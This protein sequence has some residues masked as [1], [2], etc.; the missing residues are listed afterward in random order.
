VIVLLFIVCFSSCLVSSFRRLGSAVIAMPTILLEALRLPVF[1]RFHVFGECSGFNHFYL[2]SLSV[3][4][5]V[6]YFYNI[7]CDFP[8]VKR[9][10]RPFAEVDI[11]IV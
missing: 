5:S 7:Y 10:S 11:V 2:S 1:C 8:T 6:V 4:R 9:A 3:Y